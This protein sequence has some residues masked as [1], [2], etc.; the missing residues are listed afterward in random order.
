MSTSQDDAANDNQVAAVDL[1]MHA[2]D[3][4]SNSGGTTQVPSRRERTQVSQGMV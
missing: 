2:P 1:K 4:I 3:D